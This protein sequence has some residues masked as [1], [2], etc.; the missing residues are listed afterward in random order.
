MITKQH[1]IRFLLISV[2]ALAG[3][4][5]AAGKSVSEYET[6]IQD[7]VE[8]LQLDSFGAH[9]DAIRKFWW[10]GISDERVYDIF[11]AKVKQSVEESGGRPSDLSSS[12][13][14][15]LSWYIKA[16][17]ASGNPKHRPLLEELA[18]SDSNTLNYYAKSGLEYLERFSVWNPIIAEGMEDAPPGKL[19]EWRAR[20]MLQSGIAELIRVGAERVYYEHWWKADL[21]ETANR[22]LLEHYKNPRDHRM[23]DALA[24]ICK[25]LGRSGQEVY[26]DTLKKVA[27]S[28]PGGKLRRYARKAIK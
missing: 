6:E 26:Q 5:H 27:G 22:T 13:I 28:I 24:W 3:A 16:L 14:Q 25:A 1:L 10:K 8:I 7:Y 23:V 12:R 2:C 4:A 11:A 15:E 19:G 9:R 17:G 21:L 18:Q 20:N